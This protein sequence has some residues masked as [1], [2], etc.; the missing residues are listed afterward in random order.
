MSFV[1]HHFLLAPVH[2]LSSCAIAF[3]SIS[4]HF[5]CSSNAGSRAPGSC[6]K[7][8]PLKSSER[9]RNLAAIY[10]LSKSCVDKIAMLIHRL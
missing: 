10:G 6:L 3:A 8:V 7:V 1:R 5:L 4:L 2:L 9:T